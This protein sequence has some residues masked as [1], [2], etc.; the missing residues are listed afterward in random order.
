MHSLHQSDHSSSKSFT[1]LDCAAEFGVMWFENDCMVCKLL[2]CA[3]TNAK[4][5]VLPNKS[6]TNQLSWFDGLTVQHPDC[7][8]G[9]G[10]VANI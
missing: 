3:T 10:T 2:I 5:M 8:T 4:Y 7:Q 1:M 6:T 9:L